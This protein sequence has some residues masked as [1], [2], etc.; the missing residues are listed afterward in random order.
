MKGDRVMSKKRN[1]A[2]L[3]SCIAFLCLAALL[4]ALIQ[5]VEAKKFNKAEAKKKV[6]VTYKRLSDGVLAIYKNKNKTNLKLTATMH[7]MD[8]DKKDISVDEQI[9]LC[10]TGNSTATFFF[11]APRNE[12]G[13]VIN[14]SSYKGSFSVDKSKKTSRIKNIT[15]SSTLETIEG[16]FVAVNSGSKKLSN[17]HATLV[18]Y[19]DD[20]TVWFCNTKSLSCFNPNDIDQ[21]SIN[22]V[23]KPYR[24]SKVKVYI[25][26]AY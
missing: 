8:G 21:F 11:P 1:H 25:D 7:F 4:T 26:W 22:Y 18:F 5:P 10:L 6:S 24:P 13:Q 16:K 23:D 19:A 3:R 17:V 2:V 14:Y 15:I 12:Y 20:G 9:N